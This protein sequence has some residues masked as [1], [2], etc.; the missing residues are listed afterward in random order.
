MPLGQTTPGGPGLLARAAPLGRRLRSDAGGA[1]LLLAATILALLW[2]NLPF[3]DSYEKFWHTE[4]AV[5]VGGADLALDLQH[6]VNDGLMT[7]FFFVIGLEVK[8]ELVLGEL[9]DRK[10]MAVPAL[11]AL[12][13]LVTPALIYVLFNLGE[14]SAAAWGVVISTDT[15]F[16]LGVLVLLGSAVPPQLRVFLLALAIADDVGALSVIALFYTKDLAVVPLA[17]SALVVG[18]MFALRWLQVWRGPAY[19]VL[20]VVAW[21]A[22]YESG[23]HPTLLGVIIALATPAYEAR[24]D[25][26][27]DVARRTRAYLQSPNPQYARAAQLS[28]ERSVPPGERQRRHW[29]P[30]TA[31]VF[32]PL[33]ALA[34]AGVELSPDTLRTAATSSVTLGVVAG[35]VLGK[36]AGVTLGAGLAV[37]LRLGELAPGLRAA[38]VTGGAILTGIGFTISLFIVDLAFDDDSLA[39]QARVGVLGASLLAALLGSAVMRWVARRQPHAARPHALTPPIDPERDHL[40]GPTDAPLTLVEYGDFECPFCG[41]V[42]GTIEDLRARFGNRLRYVF[43]HAPL[44]DIHPHAQ[45][46]A[47]AAEA[48][49]AQGRFWEM[50]DRLY[51]ARDR[52]SGADLLD[53]AAALDLDLPRF[54]RDL[55]AGRYTRI[56]QHDLESADASGVAGTPTF[57]VNG[58]RHTG[59][60]D[61]DTLAHALVTSSNPELAAGD[62]SQAAAEATTRPDAPLVAVV[63]LPD[64]PEDAPETPERGGDHPRLDD[65]QLAQLERVGTRRQVARGDTLYRAGEPGYDFHVILSGAVAVVG[66]PPGGDQPVVRVHGPR[67]FL[68]ELDLFSPQPVLRTAVVIRDGEVLRLTVDEL[69]N[70]LA[71]DAE[72]RDLIV[73]AYLSRR[74]IRYELAADLRIIGR[75]ESPEVRRLQQYAQAHHLTSAVIDID[76]DEAGHHFLDKVGVTPDALPVVVTRTGAVLHQPD[77]TALAEA[78]PPP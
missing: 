22:L 47:E 12:A 6:W 20:A 70:A 23:V 25:E 1:V 76:T 2:A 30:W 4:I 29:E 27:E 42:T 53:H 39:D 74:A 52:L 21:V 51:A 55:G 19:L 9:A 50:Y 3:G 32:V 31:G 15:A 67:R 24:P 64:I 49:A 17:V 43:R 41:R 54:A 10:R 71:Q 16:L 78:L 7:F 5:R 34:N 11:A 13:G 35:L 61:A 28:I 33:F 14:E 57:F 26:V 75:G 66:Q 62:P 46:A 63:N 73:R 56:V 38:N 60:T 44:A 68:G 40:R 65:E 37:R 36:L 72:T 58:Q 59:P 48:A 69:Q 8:H 45:L 18:L 77:E